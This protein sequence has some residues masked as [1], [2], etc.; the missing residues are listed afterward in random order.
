[1]EYGDSIEINNICHDIYM[2][3]YLNVLICICALSVLLS[4]VLNQD[5]KDEKNS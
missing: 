3:I 4:A 2:S 1:M 5:K